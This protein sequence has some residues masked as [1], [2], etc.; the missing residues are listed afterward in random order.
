MRL[1]SRFEVDYLKHLI[2]NNGTILQFEWD[3]DKAKA[4]FLKHGVSFEEAKS[5]FASILSADFI[6]EGHSAEEERWLKIGP[7]DKNRILVICYVERANVV[8][9]ISARNAT[10]REVKTY[11]EKRP[12]D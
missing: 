11:E 12:K 1:D 2:W 10:K 4:N 6:D 5:V 9:L 3:E 7:S 8:R